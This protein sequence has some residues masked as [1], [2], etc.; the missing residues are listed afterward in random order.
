MFTDSIYTYVYAGKH[1]PA[2]TMASVM[3]AKCA[4]FSHTEQV[5]MYT[6]VPFL[7]KGYTIVMFTC[8]WY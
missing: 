8:N 1:D 2:T 5:L 6:A 7:D 3:P 4:G